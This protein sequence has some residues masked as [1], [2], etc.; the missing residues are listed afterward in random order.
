MERVPC[1]ISILALQVE[2]AS[3]DCGNQR[4]PARQIVTGLRET[5]AGGGEE[6]PGFLAQKM[7]EENTFVLEC[8]AVRK[9]NPQSKMVEVGKSLFITSFSG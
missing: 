3:K 1:R 5:K 8:Y 4:K 9:E 6:R 2:Q 7:K